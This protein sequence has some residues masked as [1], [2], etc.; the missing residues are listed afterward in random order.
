LTRLLR[1]LKI[2]KE[3][4]KILKF[5]GRFLK[6]G[7]GFERLFFF[8]LIFLLLIHISACFWVLIASIIDETDFKGT[9]IQNYNA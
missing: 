3:K 5:L 1:I 6:I 7:L 4:S 9:W 8:S 2:I